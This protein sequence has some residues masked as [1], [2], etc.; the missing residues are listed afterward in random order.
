MEHKCEWAFH[1]GIN[2]RLAQITPG[3]KTMIAFDHGGYFWFFM[4]ICLLTT[5]TYMR[6]TFSVLLGRMYVT[7]LTGK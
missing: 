6:P 5:V 7:M 2:V 3:M 4:W 1:E